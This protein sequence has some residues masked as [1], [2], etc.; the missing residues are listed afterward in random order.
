MSQKSSFLSNAVQLALMIIGFIIFNRY[1]CS[2]ES[3][4]T[5]TEETTAVDTTLYMGN[6][7]VLNS[8]RSHIVD[9]LCTRKDFVRK[10]VTKEVNTIVDRKEQ[11]LDSLVKNRV[12]T[13]KEAST[14]MNL[15]IR[16]LMYDI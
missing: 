4:E 16:K 2:R 7:K 12:L 10:A 6:F 1:A 5:V 13:I 9:T 14:N 11:E 15:F 3:S 8:E